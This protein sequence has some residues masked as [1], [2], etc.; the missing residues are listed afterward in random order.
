MAESRYKIKGIG[1][2]F[3]ASHSS[4][5]NIK[6]KK[7]DWN[8]QTG[9][10]NVHVDRGLMIRPDYSFEKNKT[11]GWV[12][13]SKFIVPDVYNFLI[14]N[15]KILFEN[16]YNKIFTCDHELLSLHKNFIYCPNGSNY[17]WVNKNDWKIYSKNKTC[18]MFC[19]PKLMT[20]GHVYRHQIARLALDC[21]FDVFG[22][23]HGTK[24]TVTDIRNPWNTKIDGIRDY[25]F[26][27][28][29]ENG[30]Y[31]AYTTEKITDC[32]ATGTIPIYVGTKQIP[33]CFDPQGIIWLE[34]D[35]E[36]QIL[37]TLTEELYIS[38]IK[39]IEH[40]L[41]ALSH[42]KLADDYLYEMIE[43]E[44]FNPTK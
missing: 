32:F 16:Y 38:K 18:S 26:S 11:F 1:L 31:D 2:P 34:M 22:G 27:I 4:C 37:D 41:N 43:H 19:S 13:E 17:P 14:H 8:L 10:C 23:A 21:G 6:P 36:K 44:I 15:Y 39:S 5:S 35:K 20:E 3:D 28:V 25:M 12:C 40:N 30:V 29:V 42:F 9:I 7:F 24:R 33:S